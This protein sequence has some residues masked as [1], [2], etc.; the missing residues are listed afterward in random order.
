MILNIFIMNKLALIC[1]AVTISIVVSSCDKNELG[2]YTPK[3]KITQ[4]YNEVDGHMLREQWTWDGD[5]L[6]KIDYYKKNGNVDYTHTYH[7]DGNR[8]VRI[9]MD[10][11]HTD[12]VYD[13]KRLSGINAYSGDRLLESYVLSYTGKKL[14][15]ISM[16]RHDK[17]PAERSLMSLFMP[18]AGQSFV[19][20]NGSRN[21]KAE[22]YNFSAAEVD[23]LWEGNN[24]EYMRMTL[25]RPDSVQHL[26]V[27]YLYD[28]NV[29]VR[30][31]LFTLQIDHQL[32][33]NQPQTLLFSQNNAT[34]V[35]VTD[36]YDVYSR[37]TSY[38]YSY[39]YYKKYP[40][41]VYL[42]T[43]NHETGEN[44]ENHILS[45]QYMY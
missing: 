41:K 20:Y 15:H 36:K 37:T 40:T 9:D 34:S 32:V 23:L 17:K 21:D 19:A 38:N 31:P 26:D 29:N 14:T 35:F 27:S 44:A 22:S 42:I 43:L 8:L 4:V 13:G 6:S 1:V 7:Y 10:N 2:T 24:V 16:V 5:L 25:N 39:D 28:E 30:N 33:N 11:M 45:Y 12:F 18:D 3:M